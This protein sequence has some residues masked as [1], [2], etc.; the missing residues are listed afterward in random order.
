MS[1]ISKCTTLYKSLDEV[2]V[3]GEALGFDLLREKKSHA[4]YGRMVGDSAEGI[5]TARE[6]GVENLGKCDHVLRLKTHQAGDYEI[7]VKRMDDGT[8]AL[9]YDSWGPGKRLEDA[10]GKGLQRFRQ[11]YAVAVTQARMKKTLARQGFRMTREQG[12]NGRVRLRLQRR[13]G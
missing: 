1:H 7:G 13:V 9:V 8:F 10:A 12:E 11:E 3:A 6:F 4:W 5:A 2:E